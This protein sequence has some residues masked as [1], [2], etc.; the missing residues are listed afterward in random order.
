MTRHERC[1]WCNED[2]AGCCPSPQEI[3]RRSRQI[4][5]LWSADERGLRRSHLTDVSLA[6][7][8]GRR[9]GVPVDEAILLPQRA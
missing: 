1:P 3:R 2:H 7:N 8:R 9:P 5:A 4:R 6:G